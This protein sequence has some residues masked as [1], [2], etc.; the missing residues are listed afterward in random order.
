M[1]NQSIKPLTLDPND[2]RLP[3]LPDGVQAFAINAL[4]ENPNNNDGYWIGFGAESFEDF[5][6]P[7]THEEILQIC[8]AKGHDYFSETYKIREESTGEKNVFEHLVVLAYILE[9]SRYQKISACYI[10]DCNTR[11][12]IFDRAESKKME[13]EGNNLD[14][15]QY[16]ID[17]INQNPQ[18]AVYKMP[19]GWRAIDPS[20]LVLSKN[21]QI[22]WP[23]CSHSDGSEIAVNL[24]KQACR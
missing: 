9:D 11:A 17:Q 19:G 5:A 13:E 18:T 16:W 24:Q 8:Q 23:A 2:R 12:V 21:G 4:V 3:Q 7:L 20:D 14:S 15:Y 10:S 6:Q 22:L 1:S